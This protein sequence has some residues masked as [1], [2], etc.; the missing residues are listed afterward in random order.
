[1]R[2]ALYFVFMTIPLQ[3]TQFNPAA[4]YYTRMLTSLYSYNH[5]LFDPDYGLS[6]DP[7]I[8]AKLMRD[9]DI[10][11]AIQTRLHAVAARDWKIEPY[12]DDPP[13]AALAEICY[14]ALRQ[15]TN[16]LAARVNLAKACLTGRSYAWMVGQRKHMRLGHA[17]ADLWWVPTFLEEIDKRRVD[18]I[19]VRGP[20]RSLT[21]ERRLW[22]VERDRWEQIAYPDALLEYVYEDEECRLGYGRGL[23]EALFFYSRFKTIALEKGLQALDRYAGGLVIAKIDDQRVGS[24]GKGNDDVRTAYR[25]EL[26]KQRSEHIFTMPK[27]DAIEIHDMPAGGHSAAVE[28]VKLLTESMVRLLLGGLLPSGHGEGG[29][30]ARAREEGDQQEGL[31]QF[32]RAMLDER[33]TLS[34]IGLFMRQNRPQLA[35]LGLS[36]ARSSQFRTAQQKREDYKANAE[37]LKIVLDS[38]ADIGSSEYYKLVGLTPVKPGEDVV[39]GRQAAMPMPGNPFGQ[40]PPGAPDPNALPAVIDKA[41]EVSGEPT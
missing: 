9:P 17:T 8:Y 39:S 16:F 37:R 33:I 4:D 20:D 18:I 19:P 7:D 36:E 30:L 2:I 21:A 1:M 41:K 25:D 32:E 12:S 3:Y 34:L 23:G 26:A 5:R 15:I 24:V 28:F 31:I 11:G 35:R 10:C 27:G 6:R 29:S 38:G 14:D 40:Q 22:S 13:D